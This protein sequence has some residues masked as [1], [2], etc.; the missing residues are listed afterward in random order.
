MV[1][2]LL[3][4]TWRAYG[5]RINGTTVQ[6]DRYGAMNTALVFQHIH[7]STRIVDLAF[8]GVY[9]LFTAA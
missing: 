9:D 2:R 8:H 4:S 6:K 7:S 5:S 3:G 1:Q